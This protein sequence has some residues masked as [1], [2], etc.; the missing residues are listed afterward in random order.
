VTPSETGGLALGVGRRTAVATTSGGS[1][2]GKK[3][4]VATAGRRRWRGKRK[5]GRLF[6]YTPKFTDELTNLGRLCHIHFG[7][8]DSLVGP[9]HRRI[10]AI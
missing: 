1:G 2:G 9:R 5:E 8:V 7:H 10:Y 3:M 4:E 6:P